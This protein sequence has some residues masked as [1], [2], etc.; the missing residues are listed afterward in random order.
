MFLICMVFVSN[1]I[2]GKR[3]PAQVKYHPNIPLDPSSF[4]AIYST[5]SFIKQELKQKTSCC[6]SLAFDLPLGWNASEVKAD[7][8]PQFDGIDL[9]LG[10]LQQLILFMDAECKSMEDTGLKEL[11]STVYKENSL[12]KMLEGKAYS[13]CLRASLLTDTALN[14]HN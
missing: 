3:L 8:S 5:M 13:R 11:W 2:H 14:S 1:I 10:C 7:K 4:D 9:R 12:P 6:T